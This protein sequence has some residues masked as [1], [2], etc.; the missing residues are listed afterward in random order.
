MIRVPVVPHLSH[1]SPA[2]TDVTDGDRRLIMGGCA[3]NSKT[4]FFRR[5]NL[6]NI[7]VLVLSRLQNIDTG[8]VD[9]RRNPTCS[10]NVG[11]IPVSLSPVDQFPFQ[12]FRE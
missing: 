10:T 5:N 9:V 12:L 8:G 3:G 6:L 2:N 11:L 1:S 4:E 7:F